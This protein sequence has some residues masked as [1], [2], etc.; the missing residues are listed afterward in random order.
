VT[1]SSLSFGGLLSFGSVYKPHK[2]QNSYSMHIK[3]LSAIQ[4]FLTFLLLLLGGLVHNTESSLACPDW[5][6]CYG[7]VFPKM[8]GGI[9]VEHSHR[10]LASLVGFFSILIVFFTNK[11]KT[12]SEEHSH[13]NVMAWAS[14][15]MVILQGLLGGITVIYKL[16]TVVSTS[17]LALSMVFFCAIIYFYHFWTWKVLKN[18]P[19]ELT[20]E[21]KNEWTASF[22][23]LWF[24]GGI[25]IYL[26]IVLGAFMRHSGAGVA[27]GL[28]MKNTLKC[29]DSEAWK[30]FLWPVSLPA[31]VH[32]T[33]RW[34]AALLVLVSIALMIKSFK[35][36]S[37]VELKGQSKKFLGI[38]SGLFF[39]AVFFQALLGI[40][41]VG[42]NLAVTPTTL[43]LGMGALCLAISWKMFLNLWTIERNTF[44]GD[45]INT[46]SDYISLLKIRLAGLVM[47][48]VLIGMLLAPGE[49]SFFLSIKSMFFV[50]LVVGGAC[51]LNC[52]MEKDVDALMDRTKD[53]PLP[54][55]RLTSRSVLIFGW[56]ISLLG[57]AGLFIFV[58]WLTA[59]LAILAWFFY[60]AL[61]T[62]I[63]T[64]SDS[65]LFFGA[66]PGA[67]PP[68]LG[69][70][71]VTGQMDAL[72]WILFGFLFLWQLPHFLAIS[73]Y[74]LQDYS[75][76]NIKIV[77]QRKG[78][79][80]TSIDI[81]VYTL[82][83]LALSLTPHYYGYTGNT[84][85]VVVFI[86]GAAFLGHSSLGVFKVGNDLAF[87]SWARQYF[88]GSVFYLPLV[89]GAILFLK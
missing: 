80:R 75:A 8:E 41:S 50:F 51:S 32:M 44:H 43:H 10:L 11:L 6:L 36:L 88:W 34:M 62:P 81:F 60:L 67:I 19:V 66:V 9:L 59:A 58:N 87:K 52:F 21:T 54:T 70:T 56:S 76:A 38:W 5:P 28:G 71:T 57:F 77:P 53:R 1:L 17:H 14:L 20:E 31:Q 4:I 68:L 73:I 45:L 42:K 74:Y 65:A 47:T 12:T 15:G 3:R 26:Q 84:Y 82:G 89:L 49:L 33:H 78:S 69:W 63:K 7:Q 39:M 86:L 35:L 30:H 79:R 48:T 18:E 22:K 24:A 13:A 83:L 23:Q 29:F 61:Y 46:L 2:S 72:A 27:C 64:K 25:L 37:K 40:F 85:V 16:P 55:G